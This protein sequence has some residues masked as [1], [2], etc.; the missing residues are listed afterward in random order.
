MGP[1][2]SGRP[3]VSLTEGDVVLDLDADLVGAR[4]CH[5]LLPEPRGSSDPAGLTVRLCIRNLVLGQQGGHVT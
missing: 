5:A 2:K 1:Q 3:V 4:Q